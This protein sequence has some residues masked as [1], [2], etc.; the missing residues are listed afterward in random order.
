M[1]KKFILIFHLTIIIIAAH[2]NPST[3]PM[4]KLFWPYLHT[5][6]IDVYMKPFTSD[7]VM[8]YDAPSKE[9]L[10]KYKL[11]ATYYKN[12][13]RI[14]IKITDLSFHRWRVPFTWFALASSYRED[15][16]PYVYTL[17]QE[18][19]RVHGPGDGFTLSIN[20]RDDIARI[21]G[22]NTYY[23]CNKK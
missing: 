11:R 19:E 15:L 7:M 20:L 4:L 3:Y 2:P 16:T 10:Y 14:P 22:L 6:G 18:L 13:E 21:Y 23:P 17:C 1:I 9:S 8:M 5:L 12:K